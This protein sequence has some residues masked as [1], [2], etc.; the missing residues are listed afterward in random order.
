MTTEVT[1]QMRRAGVLFVR[2]TKS[3]EGED[4]A[5]AMSAICYALIACAKAISVTK[6]QVHDAIE[7][8]WDMKL[9]G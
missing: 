9:G 5:A 1:R 4:G 2:I 7:K 8:S 3:V 6:E